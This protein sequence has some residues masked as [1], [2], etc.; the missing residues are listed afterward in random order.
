MQN[1][2]K[3]FAPFHANSTQYIQ[4]RSIESL[5]LPPNP[6]GPYM[7]QNREQLLA[8]QQI[9]E[10]YARQQKRQQIQQQQASSLNQYQSAQKKLFLQQ[11]IQQ[12]QQHHSSNSSRNIDR[13]TSLPPPG[14]NERFYV[15]PAPRYDHDRL[16]LQRVMG[17]QKNTFNLGSHQSRSVSDIRMENNIGFAANFNGGLG[18]W[19]LQINEQLDE[20][21]IRY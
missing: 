4:S 21:S 9:L 1:E 5:Q 20:N 2:V 16:A 17:Q 13:V 10:Q 3:S 18:D 19:R 15:N 12:Q 8:K 11:Q 7:R 6:T 14:L